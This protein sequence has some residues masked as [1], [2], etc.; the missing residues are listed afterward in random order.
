MAFVEE[1]LVMGLT[2]L[3]VE[4]KKENIRLA[5]SFVGVREL[6]FSPVLAF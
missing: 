6:S 4:P 3:V 5:N 2:N 1:G